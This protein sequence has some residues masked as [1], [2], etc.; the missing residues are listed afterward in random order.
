MPTAIDPSSITRARRLRGTM[1]DGEKKLWSELREFRRW[2][3]IHVRRQWPIGPFIADF[4]IHEKKLVI[5]IDGEHHQYPDQIA[6]DVKRDHWFRSEGYEVFRISSG[7]VW[8]NFDGCVEETL[9][10]VGI[11]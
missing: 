3:G 11:A 1:T 9:R 2:Y 6:E 5:E 4:V 8:D 10:K 7:D